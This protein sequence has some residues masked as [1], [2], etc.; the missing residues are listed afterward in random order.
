MSRKWDQMNRPMDTHFGY[1]NEWR[2]RLQQAENRVNTSLPASTQTLIT[3]DDIPRPGFGASSFSAIGHANE[4]VTAMT[5]YREIGIRLQ[6]QDRANQVQG[7][8]HEGQSVVVAIDI[9]RAPARFHSPLDAHVNVRAIRPARSEAEL[10]AADSMTSQEINRRNQPE[11][12]DAD[13]R[14]LPPDLETVT[15]EVRKPRLGERDQCLVAEFGPVQQVTTS[16]RVFE[17]DPTPEVRHFVIKESEL[18]QWEQAKEPPPPLEQ[19]I[20][21]VRKETF[22]ETNVVP[23]GAPTSINDSHEPK[24]NLGQP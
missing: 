14:P 24:F 2:R 4:L 16:F 10:R 8:L 20:L 19:G 1:T 3:A 5:S 12:L 21:G 17:L 18:R 6:V 7:Q 22:V 9:D 15:I 23:P 13:L 11:R